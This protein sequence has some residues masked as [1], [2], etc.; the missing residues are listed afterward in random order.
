MHSESAADH[1]LLARL[2]KKRAD[3]AEH[4]AERKGIEMTQNFETKHCE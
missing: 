1:E 4:D 3:Q 2:L